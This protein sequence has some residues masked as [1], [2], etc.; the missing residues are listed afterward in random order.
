MAWPSRRPAL[1]VEQRKVDSDPAR[2]SYVLGH[3]KQELIRLERQARIFAEATD[4]VLHRAG[5]REGMTVL[6]VGCGVG[7]VTLAAAR[8]VG[9]KGGVIGIDR[10][11]EA[12]QT[13][14]ARV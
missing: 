9:P 14:R 10:A 8:M 3:S 4:D 11:E 12:L 5:I 6:D 2:P 1:R 13:A 7:D